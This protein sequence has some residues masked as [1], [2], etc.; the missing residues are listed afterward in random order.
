MTSPSSGDSG[1]SSVT[2]KGT[3]HFKLALIILSQ[4]PKGNDTA[5]H[6]LPLISCVFLLVS[7]IVA[8]T[9]A[10]RFQKRLR[11][12]SYSLDYFDDYAAAYE[13]EWDSTDPQSLSPH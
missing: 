10:G 2:R 8:L 3:P 9:L 5:I 4:T 12:V 11:F 6:Y 1:G 13:K 7:A